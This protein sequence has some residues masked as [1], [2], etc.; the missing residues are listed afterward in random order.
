MPALPLLNE[1][2]ADGVVALREWRPVDRDALVEM[3]NDETIQRWTRVPAPYTDRDA[4]E[5]FALTRTTRAAGHQAAFAVVDPDHG[6]LLGSIDLRVNPAD[7]AIGE[8]GYIVGPR[9]RGRGVLRCY[10]PGRDGGRLDLTMYGRLCSDE[11][12]GR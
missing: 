5:W 9:A 2:L 3:A 7:P 6:E 1:P 10:R 4:D 12:A 8:L 11:P